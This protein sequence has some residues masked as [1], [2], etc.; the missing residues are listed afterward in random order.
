M[1]VQEL[2]NKYDVEEEYGMGECSI[3]GAVCLEY[4]KPRANLVPYY[5]HPQPLFLA[6]V[7]AQV[8]TRIGEQLLIDIC[9]NIIMACEDNDTER[10]MHLLQRVI[11]YKE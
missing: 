3:A 8:N 11:D 6:E 5:S 9:D 7:L 10:A 1:K 2:L 4:K